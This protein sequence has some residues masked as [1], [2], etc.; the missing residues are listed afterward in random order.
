MDRYRA[1]G[2]VVGSLAE[3]QIPLERDELG[4]QICQDQPGTAQ[5]S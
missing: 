1:I 5:A 3:V 2:A 4:Q